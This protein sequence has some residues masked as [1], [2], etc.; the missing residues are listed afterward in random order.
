[1]TTAAPRYPQYEVKRTIDLPGLFLSLQEQLAARFHTSRTYINHRPTMGAAAEQNW[2]S[3]LNDYLPLRYSAAAAFVV[4]HRG[5]ISQQIDIVIYDRQY[6]ML[7]FRQDGVLYVP[8]ESVYAVFD[9]KQQLSRD[10][11]LE[12]A[13]KAESVRRLHRTSAAITHAGGT[14]KPRP[15]FP[16]L[17]GVLSLGSL[18]ADGIGESITRILNEFTPA[19]MLDLGCAVD[20]GA[21][22]ATLIENQTTKNKAAR[23][24]PGGNKLT[25]EVAPRDSALSFFLVRLLHRLQQQGTA[26]AIDLLKYS[27]QLTTKLL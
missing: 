12:S 14:F 9:V 18:W 2:L 10:K 19:R 17:A 11:V 6:S 7:L 5:H 22:E 1:M 3:L 26:P 25:V 16:I 4:D 21:F 15:P 24:H 8:A 23:N 27:T 13:D 20:C